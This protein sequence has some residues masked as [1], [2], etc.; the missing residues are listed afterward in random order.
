MVRET[1]ADGLVSELSTAAEAIGIGEA[2]LAA[3]LGD[4]QTIAEVARANGVKP[5]R[6]VTALVARV[7]ADVAA[8]I[9]RGELSPGQVR[10]LVALATQRA[11]DQVV[12][13]FPPIEFRPRGTLS[14]A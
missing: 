4:G 8:E 10:W 12:S 1:L 6:V 3:A 9:R 13:P 11:E 2:S 14:G 5:R 7:V